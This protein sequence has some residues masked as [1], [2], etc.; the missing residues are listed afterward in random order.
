METHEPSCV[1]KSAMPFF[2]LEAHGPQKVTGHAA[3]LELS[4]S[5][6]QDPEPYDTWRCRSPPER[7]GGVQSHGHVVVSEPFPVGIQG[8]EP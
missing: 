3:A 8:L 4:Q 7:G 1:A 6:R 5:G 2:I